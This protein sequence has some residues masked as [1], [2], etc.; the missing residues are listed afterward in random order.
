M[1]THF[2]TYTK[3]IPP[4]A[5]LSAKEMA[6]LEVVRNERFLRRT[7]MDLH[8]VRF[9][10]LRMPEKKFVPVFGRKVPTLG[11]IRR[12]LETLRAYGYAVEIAAGKWG[13]RR[14]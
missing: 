5:I 4:A 9:R 12:A 6:V 14:A 13:V 8:D 7:G 11:C 10:L 1:S 2:D 3:P